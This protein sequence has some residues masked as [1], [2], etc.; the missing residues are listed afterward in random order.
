MT[1]SDAP[2]NLMRA[3]YVA[4]DMC[5]AIADEA[6]AIDAGHPS[7]FRLDTLLR[8][9]SVLRRIDE[10]APRVPPRMHGGDIVRLAA[11]WEASH[12]RA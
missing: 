8:A 12:D 5:R 9:F 11:E 10:F 2:G 1:R 6:A 7:Q 4:E 3:A